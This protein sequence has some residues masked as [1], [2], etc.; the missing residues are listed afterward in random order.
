MLW[1]LHHS[2]YI[3][4]HKRGRGPWP[5]PRF[6]NL[7]FSYYIFSKKGC[8][9]SF[10]RKKLNF[11]IFSHP[12]KILGFNRKILL[13]ASLIHNVW[14]IID[15]WWTTVLW[16]GS[17][18]LCSSKHF[19]WF[20]LKYFF[21]LHIKG[22]IDLKIFGAAFGIEGGNCPH[23]SPPWLRAWVH[24][25]CIKSCAH[26]HPENFPGNHCTQA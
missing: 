22:L 7:T 25:V 2:H 20:T 21:G 23:C 11:T 12:T 24:I 26:H 5:L 13:F 8:L 3:R 14:L 4:N 9:L 1:I 17:T 16:S 19:R 6:W 15:N 10:E 18:K